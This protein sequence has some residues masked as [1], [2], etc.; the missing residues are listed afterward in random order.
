MSWLLKQA[1]DIL[2]RV[3][4]QT[5]AAI[6]HQTKPDSDKSSD[7]STS[8]SSTMS[9]SNKSKNN[10]SR[11]TTTTLT[12]NRRPKKSDEAD[13]I[14]YLNSP[15]SI[16][17]R[18]SRSVLS[19]NQLS[20]ATRTASSPDMASNDSSSRAVDQLSSKSASVTPRSNTPA[21]QSH[22]DDEGLVL[23]SKER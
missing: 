19:N 3:D 15:S 5:N 21:V 11:T 10:T 22:D 12:G 18:S 17:N 7:E 9:S 14:D 6:N 4:Q 8:N 16:E 2:N 20:E 23:V 1:E 13:L